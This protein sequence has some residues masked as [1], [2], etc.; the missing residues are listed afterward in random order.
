MSKNT[1]F[2]QNL[3]WFTKREC[4]L[5]DRGISVE[6]KSLLSSN[7]FTI[8]YSNIIP[9]VLERKYLHL[10][11]LI[12]TLLCILAALLFLYFYL[13]PTSD[14]PNSFWTLSVLFGTFTLYCLSTFNKKSNNLSYFKLHD[15]GSLAFNSNSPSK[16]AVSQFLEKIISETTVIRSQGGLSTQEKVAYYQ[17]YL[18]FLYQEGVMTKDELLVINE[19]L[20]TP[21]KSADILSIV[22]E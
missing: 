17:N 7:K 20:T 21:V 3:D 4:I 6:T 22:R 9:E 8:R 10:P 18:K 2:K 12:G 19:R 5:E 13:F 14:K 16:K 11:S 15:G 1:K